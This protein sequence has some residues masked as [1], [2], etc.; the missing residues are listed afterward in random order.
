MPTSSGAISLTSLQW[1]KMQLRLAALEQSGSRLSCRFEFHGDSVSDVT[2]HIYYVDVDSNP[3]NRISQRERAEI[4]E[5][6]IAFAMEVI[7]KGLEQAELPLVFS[8]SPMLRFVLY[9][10]EG[11]GGM[12][13]HRAEA[14]FHWPES[15]AN[16]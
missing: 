14:A 7:R 10:S 16:S 15:D 9:Q 11:M 2:C 3:M 4:Y 1:L 5:G 6:W 13:V 8:W 12:V